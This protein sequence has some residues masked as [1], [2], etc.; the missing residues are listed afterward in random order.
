M[1]NSSPHSRGDTG[2]TSG[3]QQVLVI[4]D[5]RKLC[6]L[7]EQYLE[8]L[9][10]DVTAVHTGPEGAQRAVAEA[11][12][13]VILD[14]MLPGQDGYEVLKEI[15]RHSEVPVLMLTARGEEA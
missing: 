7:I 11:W 3:R 14:V 13:A 5:D 8:P 10:Y 4:D 9:G 1:S 15:R 2:K 12:T 6:R